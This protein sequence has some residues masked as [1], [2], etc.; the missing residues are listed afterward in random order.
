MAKLNVPGEIQVVEVTRAG[1]SSIPGTG[2]TLRSGDLVRFVVA[3][4]ALGRLRGFVGGRW[5]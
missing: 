2:A 3:S 5:A 1:H 4:R